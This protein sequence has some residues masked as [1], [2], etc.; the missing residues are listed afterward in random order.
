MMH[1]TSSVGARR[2]RWARWARWARRKVAGR[3]VDGGD[4][5]P[6]PRNRPGHLPGDSLLLDRRAVRGA[7]WSPQAGAPGRGARG[8]RQ[9]GADVAGAGALAAGPL[10]A[11]VRALRRAALARVL[12][13]GA[14]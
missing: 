12:P 8:E 5:T 10:R 1:I 11:P 9:R 4:E 7:V 2:A 13:A 14:L 3:L 6:E